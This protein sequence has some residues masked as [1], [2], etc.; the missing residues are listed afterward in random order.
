MMYPVLQDP[1]VTSA[2]LEK[3]IDFLRA[4]NLTQEEIDISLARVQ[5]VVPPFAPPVPSQNSG[6]PTQQSIRQGI[7]YGYGY[8]PYPPGPWS[9]PQQSVQHL[10]HVYSVHWYIGAYIYLGLLNGI[11]AIGYALYSLATRYILPLIRPPTPPQLENDKAS[12]DESFSRAFTLIE[13][14]ASDTA[15]LKASEQERTEKLDKALEDVNVVVQK[16]KDANKRRESE[17]RILVDQLQELRDLVPQALE[18]W[19]A[20]GDNRL[21][22]LGGELRSLKK[23]VANRVGSGTVRSSRSSSALATERE[24]EKEKDVSGVSETGS[25]TSNVN[26]QAMSK[27]GHE[28]PRSES[29]TP[30]NPFATA[31]KRDGLTQGKRGSGKA[32]IPAWQMAASSA[33]SGEKKKEANGVGEA[34]VDGTT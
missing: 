33:A 24:R 12:I 2:P 14:L 27:A 8:G 34:G 16:I 18:S 20:Q 25:A 28:P 29:G 17:N 5:E 1:S 21:D 22:D 31:L 6:Y 23:L 26:T 30:V 11:G 3:R 13:Q 9:Q 7:G 4:K 32:V 19:R 15:A 10:F